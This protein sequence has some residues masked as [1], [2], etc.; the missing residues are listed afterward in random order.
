MMKNS[1]Q[2][3]LGYDYDK[4]YGYGVK[5]PIY[6]D[7]STSSNSHTLFCGMSGSG[8][9]FATHQYMARL[10]NSAPDTKLFFSDF[11]QDDTFSSLCDCSKYYG[12]ESTLTALDKVYSIM[13]KRQSGDNQ[14]RNP[15]TLIWDEYVANILYLQ[16]KNKKKAEETMRK[17]SEIL[18][19]GRSLNVRLVISCQRPDAVAFP[20]GSRL[21]YGIIIILGAPIKSIYEML[22]PKEYIDLIGDRKFGIG[23][24]VAL[25]QSSELHFIK[26]PMVRNIEKMQQ[27]CITALSDCSD[28]EGGGEAE[29]PCNQKQ[30][31]VL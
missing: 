16:N 2:I 30:S 10:V 31:P 8:K 9:S 22:I 13:H 28:C 19:L 1:N 5:E 15:I 23:E 6:T 24:G 21:N 3:L 11:K 27:I 17:V 18:M 14:S 25:L 20:T 26:I 4:W 12:F 29:S 7:I